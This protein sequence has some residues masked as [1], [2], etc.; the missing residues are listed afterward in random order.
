MGR[1]QLVTYSFQEIDP[2][3]PRRWMHDMPIGESVR[4]FL[5]DGFA[6][7]TAVSGLTFVEL[8]SRR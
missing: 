1:P 2:L 5:R 6:E 3:F 8:P 7:W 4:Q